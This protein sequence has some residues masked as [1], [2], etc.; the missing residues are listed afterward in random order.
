MKP[1]LLLCLMAIA[2]GCSQPERNLVGQKFKI[3]SSGNENNPFDG[4]AYVIVVAQENGYVQYKWQKEYDAL[5][6]N[7][8]FS[9]SYSEFMKSVN[10]CKQ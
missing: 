2:V 1:L 10:R 4:F 8:K 9:R 6:L 5:D 3:C 7:V